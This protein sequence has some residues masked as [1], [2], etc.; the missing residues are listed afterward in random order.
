MLS[1]EQKSK[2]VALK[3]DLLRREIDYFFCVH[4]KKV[5]GD[6]LGRTRSGIAQF[7]CLD[8]DGEPPTTRR[9]VE[10]TPRYFCGGG[11]YYKDDDDDDAEEQECEV[12]DA[13]RTR[14]NEEMGRVFRF[15]RVEKDQ[16]RVSGDAET[17]T[18]RGT[19]RKPRNSLLGRLLA[20]SGRVAGGHIE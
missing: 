15:T 12:F 18:R 5:D 19:K 16:R 2:R 8:D 3:R 1:L 4:E 20:S 17:R 11:D 6:G 10:E 13:E 7:V 9:R 14:T